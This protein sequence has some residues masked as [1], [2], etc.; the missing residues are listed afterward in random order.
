MQEDMIAR[1]PDTK[2]I[3]AHFGSYC[4]NL[5]QVG[6]WLDQYPNMYVDIAARISEL[7]RQPY[8]SRAFLEKYSTVSV[9]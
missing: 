3:I 1:H 7:G 6:Q 8:S 9:R 2:F 5:R 4:E